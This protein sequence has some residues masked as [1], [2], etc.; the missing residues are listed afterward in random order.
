MLDNTGATEDKLAIRELIESYH[1]A[2]IVND[3]ES[4]AANWCEDGRWDLGEGTMITGRDAILE[5]WKT[6]MAV[7]DFVGMFGQPGSIRV[8]G[9]EATARWYTNE[10]C[11][12][13]DG[14]MLRIC[15]N[16]RDRYRRE[17]DRWRIAERVYKILFM[18]SPV[19]EQSG[20][21]SWR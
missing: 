6:A 16:Y 12:K 14:Q 18:Q 1:E 17:G 11:R 9:D 19:Y 7:F 15:G 21:D 5:H 8:Q 3:P 4:W 13:T 10:L 20:V 2:V